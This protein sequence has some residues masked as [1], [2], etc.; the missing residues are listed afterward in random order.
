MAGEHILK[1]LDEPDSRI[2]IGDKWLIRYELHYA[3]FFTV[4][5]HKRYGKHTRILVET[6]NEEL[7]CK[8]LKGE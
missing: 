2:S 5:Q 8:I 7:A 3:K 4:Y 6:E 1:L